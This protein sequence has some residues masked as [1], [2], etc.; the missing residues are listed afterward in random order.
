MK[1]R[2]S[3]N[4]EKSH[5]KSRKMVTTLDISFQ[6]H[7]KNDKISDQILKLSPKTDTFWLLAISE[8]SKNSNFSENFNSNLTWK[9][10]YRLLKE[11]L[12]S[13]RTNSNALTNTLLTFIFCNPT[14]VNHPFTKFIS[15]IKLFFWESAGKTLFEE[16]TMLEDS[17]KKEQWRCWT[18]F[19]WK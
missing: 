5:P 8:I 12:T 7:P 9:K 17:R 4:Q 19:S 13:Y 16:R 3:K 11:T 15:A 6:K 10:S 1:I 18:F 2:I 14:S